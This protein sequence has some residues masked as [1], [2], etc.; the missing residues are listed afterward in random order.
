MGRSK[1]VWP[2]WFRIALEQAS[3]Q[4]FAVAEFAT[5]AECERERLRFYKF[6][7]ETRECA[8][9]PLAATARDCVVQWLAAADSGK[10]KRVLR[11]ELQSSTANPLVSGTK[12]DELA[13][14]TEV[15]RLL[16]EMRT[17][18]KK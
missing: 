18:Y 11:F 12:A 3:E 10:S 14:K 8:D 15:E 2:N 5:Q 7:K 13:E 9:D 17:T 4:G 6:L 16:K 1:G